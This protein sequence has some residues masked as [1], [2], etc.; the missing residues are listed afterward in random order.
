MIIPKMG[1]I[2]VAVCEEREVT[3]CEEVAEVH[4]GVGHECSR[5][6]MALGVAQQLRATSVE[7]FP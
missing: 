7:A 4:V 5:A 6:S 3:C 2:K 1:N